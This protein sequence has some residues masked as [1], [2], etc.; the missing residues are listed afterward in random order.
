MTPQ[1]NSLHQQCAKVSVRNR[2]E[3]GSRSP[4]APLA[5]G[6][7]KQTNVCKTKW[8]NLSG[9]CESAMIPKSRSELGLSNGEFYRSTGIIAVRQK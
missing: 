2:D 3:N 1:F 9:I 8:G 4:A 5:N 7:V 6:T